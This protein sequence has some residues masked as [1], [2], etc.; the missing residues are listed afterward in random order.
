ML[1][2][3]RLLLRWFTED[4]IEPSYQMNL[5]PE[6]SRY[7]LD[8]GV[9]SRQEIHDRIHNSVFGD[10]EKYGFGRFAVIHKADN[11]F[12]GFAGLKRLEDQGEV[13]LG[14]RLR[15]EYWGQGLATEASRISLKYGFETLGIERVI[16]MAHAENVGSIHVLKKLGFKFEKQIEENGSPVVCYALLKTEML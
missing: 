8:G 11:V 6:V 10:Y 12:I 16:A 4:D 2:T 15:R 5:D 7:T 14:Y 1:E 13:D 9:C 3:E